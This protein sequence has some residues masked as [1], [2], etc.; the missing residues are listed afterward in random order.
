[1]LNPD[2]DGAMAMLGW[3]AFL[4]CVELNSRRSSSHES[5]LDSTIILWHC[6]LL[7]FHPHGSQNL[8]R[9]LSIISLGPQQASCLALRSSLG[10]IIL[11]QLLLRSLKHKGSAA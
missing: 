10:A 9:P 6:H 3:G 7:G 1:M 2:P 5:C 4:C 11:R 8:S